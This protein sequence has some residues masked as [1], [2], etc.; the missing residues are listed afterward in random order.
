MMS[1]GL[2]TPKS[3]T[4]RLESEAKYSLSLSACL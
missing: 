2:I 4:T 3:D 1:M